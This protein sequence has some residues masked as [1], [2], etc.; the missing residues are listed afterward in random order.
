[1]VREQQPPGVLDLVQFRPGVATDV[2]GPVPH[3]DRIRCAVK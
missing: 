3:L 2:R 1:M